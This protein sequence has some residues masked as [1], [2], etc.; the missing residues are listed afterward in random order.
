MTTGHDFWKI[1][2]ELSPGDWCLSR[3]AHEAATACLE[4]AVPGCSQWRV[5]ESP[6]EDNALY[7]LLVDI[8]TKQEKLPPFRVEPAN[9]RFYYDLDRFQKRLQEKPIMARTTFVWYMPDT[10][11]SHLAVVPLQSRIVQV[12]HREM[13]YAGEPE[14]PRS[15][16]Y[17]TFYTLAVC[18]IDDTYLDVYAAPPGW[19]QRI[20]R[21]RDW[22]RHAGRF[23]KAQID[24]DPTLAGLVQLHGIEAVDRALEPYRTAK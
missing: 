24:L 3:G 12:V 5:H 11:D 15:G 13:W 20:L 7:Y 23:E 21:V 8:A 19:D 10:S 6:E 17:S 14:A 9:V 22:L 18:D 16:R 4:G 1:V 2:G